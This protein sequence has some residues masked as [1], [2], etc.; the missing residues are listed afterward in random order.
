MT[1]IDQ[2]LQTLGLTPNEVAIYTY[3]TRAG[4]KDGGTIYRD[5]HID[6]SSV[7]RALSNLIGKG[8][9]Y[10]IGETR[11]QQ[12]GAYPVAT[13]M[14]LYQSKLTELEKSRVVLSSFVEDVEQYVKDNYGSQRITL[15]S[16]KDGYIQWN[17]ARLDDK[18]QLIREF[19]PKDYLY[20]G[21]P[22]YDKNIGS[23]VERRVG[24]KIPIHVL[25]ND[26]TFEHPLDKTRKDI[27]KVARRTLI[28]LD[29][30]AGLSTFGDK[31]ALITMEKGSFFGIVIKDR[32]ITRT[33]NSLFDYVWAGA[34]DEEQK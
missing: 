12:F 29:L 13:V 1:N 2:A 20:E 28:P 25:C 14:E 16:G 21:I 31:T 23:F 32:L 3:L 19:I 24:K 26:P 33:I 10:S 27:L 7:Y 17:N 18:V 30:P 9:I 22:D 11:N 4:T 34:I 6:K 5:C 15:Y 8:L